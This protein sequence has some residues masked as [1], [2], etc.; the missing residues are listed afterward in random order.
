MDEVQIVLA[1]VLLSSIWFWSLSSCQF[2]STW[3]RY[4]YLQAIQPALNFSFHAHHLRRLSTIILCAKI[5]CIISRFS[6]S[7]FTRSALS[8]FCYKSRRIIL[9]SVV[10]E[11]ANAIRLVQS[12]ETPLQYL[13]RRPIPDSKD[14]PASKTTQRPIQEFPDRIFSPY[15]VTSTSRELVS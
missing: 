10:R 14:L 9:D 11:V 1:P 12:D 7:W 15:P 4:T 13:N 8:D 3:F 2:R 5:L 6:G